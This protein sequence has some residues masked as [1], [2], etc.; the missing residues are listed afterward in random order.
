MLREGA[1]AEAQPVGP[2]LPRVQQA[3]APKRDLKG[4]YLDKDS[5][6]YYHD[7]VGWYY[8]EESGMYYGGDPPEWSK[9]LPW[10]KRDKAF[11]T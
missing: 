3:A 2:Q 11:P 6:Y 10:E 9:E 8:H 7:D 4:W 5:G 1:Q